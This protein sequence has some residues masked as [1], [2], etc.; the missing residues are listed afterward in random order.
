MLNGRDISEL[1]VKVIIKVCEYIH[2]ITTF[3]VSMVRSYK[4]KLTPSYS[5]ETLERCIAAVKNRNMSIRKAAAHYNVPYGT[6]HRRLKGTQTKK[7]GGQIYLPPA[8]EQHLVKTLDKLTD[9]KVP[10]DSFN[11]RCLVK[12]YHDSADIKHPKFV[13][14][15]PGPDW[16]RSFIKRFNLTKRI[17]DNVKAARAEVNSN[18]INAYFDNLAQAISGIPPSRIYNY[19]ETNMTDD[20]GSKTVVC[21]RGRNRVERKV[22]HSKASVSVMFCGNAAGEFVPPMVV[23]KAEN[24]YEGWTRGGPHNAMYHATKSGW[25]DTVAFEM[26]VINQFIPYISRHNGEPVV[27]IGDNL[28]AHFSGAVIEECL[29]NNVIFICLPPNSTHLCQPLDVAVFRPMKVEWRDILDTWRRESRRKENLPKDAFP[30]LLLKLHGRL[31]SSNLV[32]GFRA[33][34]I[35]PLNRNEVLKHLPTEVEDPVLEPAFN[36]AIMT[37]L[38]ENM[39]IGVEKRKTRTTRGSKIVPGTRVVN[40]DDPSVAAPEARASDSAGSS[41]SLSVASGGDNSVD[42]PA[43]ASDSDENWVCADCSEPWDDEGE[44]RWV[45]CDT[46]S[47]PFHLQCSG[48]KYKTSQY[49]YID[50]DTIAFVCDECQ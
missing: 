1:K 9:W 8:F 16:V 41:R 22:D 42:T 40:L 21:R 46:C 38:K 7:S 12:A 30:N 43:T 34:G 13:N 5:E 33:A 17:T 28:G 4:R 32:A 29:T 49:W 26:W 10:F 18:V 44:D 50:L 2:R 20:P 31:K 11:I 25:F 14:N 48:L 15:F 23:Y 45:M 35:C 6:L 24:C 3:Q 19:D 47:S 27:L 39:G 37:V 36:S